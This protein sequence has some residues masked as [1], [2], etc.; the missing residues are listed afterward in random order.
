MRFYGLD[1]VQVL[2]MPARRFWALESQISR[3]RSEE[4]LRLI[5]ANAA[6]IS[7]DNHRDVIDR[8][9]LELGETCKVQHNTIVKPEAGV[10][11]KFAMVV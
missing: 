8:L 5:S 2:N 10:K 3:L 6:T 4:D 7:E 1:D 9:T 11:S